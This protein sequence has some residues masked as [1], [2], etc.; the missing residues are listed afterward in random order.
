M[1]GRVDDRSGR[2]GLESAI[3][4]WTRRKWLALVVFALAF[5]A[6]AN[7][8]ISLPKLYRATTTVVV[9]QQQVSETVVRPTGGGDVESLDTR[10][11]LIRQELMSRARLANLIAQYD[12][13]AP[14]RNK[15]MP[16]DEI[17]DAMRRDIDL[18]LKAVDTAVGGRGP[19]IAFA[20]SYTGR[21]ASTVADVANALASLYVESNTKLREGQAVRTA[22][23]LKSQLSA[24][25]GELDAQQQRTSAF[26]VSHSGELPQQLEANLASLDR[27]NTQL[28]LNGE[29]Q[30]RLL[31]RRERLQKQLAEAPTA[32]AT[33]AVSSNG[34]RAERLAKLRQEL[35]DLR[36]QF[37]DE[38]PDVVRLRL[39][40][41]ELEKQPADPPVQ[42][43]DAPSDAGE[44]VRAQLRQAISAADAELTSLK[45]EEATFRRAI[46]AYEERVDNVPRRQEEFQALS[47]DYEA[48]KERYDTLLKRYEE[49]QLAERLEQGRNVE[50]LRILDPAI[51]PRRPFAPSRTRLL[52]I[53]I[54][55]AAGLAAAAAF[56]A[57]KLDT[58]FH[59]IADV[60]ACLNVP[61]LYTIPVIVTASDVRRRRRRM[62]LAAV[63]LAAA[64]VLVAAGA[65]HFAAGNEQLVRLTAR[66]HV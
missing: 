9:E 17:V 25:K 45:S 46:A 43:T 65:R 36:R 5:A 64:L 59:D 32:T 47:R 31:D 10:L 14:L 3:A 7:I 62:A 34:P 29:N 37:T 26:K 61:S 30:I 19:M 66:G 52:A 63:S 16:F 15:G 42:K 28:R 20:I 6:F 27:L 2:A 12:L 13:Y 38:Y 11:Q 55:L 56:G 8:A 51:P 54:V 33:N 35:A 41:A 18:D 21:D 49:A 1:T 40:I 48:T 44:D 57:D 53:G 50:Q 60:R 23:F 24:A 39:E 4:I 22:A 58:S